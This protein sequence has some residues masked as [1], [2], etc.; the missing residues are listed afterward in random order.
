MWAT[1]GDPEVMLRCNYTESPESLLFR[2][3]ILDFVAVVVF[4]V[5]NIFRQAS[6]LPVIIVVAFN[7][8]QDARLC[9]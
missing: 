6:L 8:M 2:E 7:G 5:R 9:N 4:G 1:V 3:L